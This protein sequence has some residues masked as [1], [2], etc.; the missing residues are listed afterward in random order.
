MSLSTVTVTWDQVDIGQAALAGTVT[1]ALS[2]PLGDSADGLNVNAQPPRSYRFSSGTGTSDPL[3]ANDNANL[4][5][6][7]YYQITVSIAGQQPYS[8][9]AQVNFA[10][11]ATQ[12]L[13]YL[14]ANQATTNPPAATFMPLPS[15]TPAPG[16]VPVVQTAG[17]TA[18]AWGAATSLQ[19]AQAQR[20]T[21]TS[22]LTTDVLTASTPPAF[23]SIVSAGPGDVIVRPG[24]TYQQF[25]GTGAALTDA[26]AYV[27]TN[28]MTS[29]Q[30]KALLTEL[31][32]PQQ[33]GWTM[34]RVAM[35]W[36]SFSSVPLA[37]AYTY[38]D[39]PSG[40]AD[41]SLINFSVTKDTAYI[42]P[43]IQQILAIN[44]GVRIVAAP[45]TPPAWMLATG[46]L[47]VAP[48]TF[49]D[50][51]FAAYAQ[52][53]VQFVQAYQALGIPIWAV[54]PA[55]EP[56]DPTY[57]TFTQ[58][59]ATSFVGTYLGPALAAAGLATKIL[60]L[61]D[62][63]G[64]GVTYPEG[65]LADTTAG[66][67]TA[68]VAWHGYSGGPATMSQVHGAYPAAL[69]IQTEWRSLTTESLALDMQGMAGG[70]VAGGVQNWS[71]AVL[72]WN[73]ALD[74][75]GGPQQ[76]AAGRRGAVAVNSGT[77][78]VTRNAEYYALRHLSGYVQ[79]GAVRCGSSTFGAPYVS[80]VTYPSQVTT[81]AFLNPDGSVVLYAYNGA[82]SSQTFQVIDERTGTGFPVTMV[83]G[84]LSTFVWGT[85]KQALPAVPASTPAAPSAPVLSASQGFGQTFLS[86][87]VPASAAPVTRYHLKRATTPGAE[88]TIAELPASSPFYLDLLGAAGT[89]YYTVVAVSAGGASA[90]SNEV[91]AVNAAP[92]APFAPVISAVSGGTS[93]TLSWT[94]PPPNGDVITS[95]NILRGTTSGGETSLGTA[96]Q[97]STSYTDATVTPG[98]TYY[99]KV[100]AVNVIGTSPSSNEASG[101]ATGVVIDSTSTDSN[102]ANVSSL[103]WSHT[104][105]SGAHPLLLVAV[106]YAGS[107]GGDVVSSV[108]YGGVA[109][110]KLLTADPSPGGGTDKAL[111]VW[112]LTGPAAGTASIVVTFTG[113]LSAVCGAVSLTGVSQSSPLR[114]PLPFTSTSSNAPTVSTTGGAASD[115]VMAF[116]HMR[117]ANTVTVGGSQTAVITYAQTGGTSNQLIATKQTGGTGTIVSSFS[118][119]TPDMAAEIAVAV[120]AG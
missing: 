68:G 22:D 73:M 53:F 21:T 51:N 58:S 110:T 52:Y 87:T 70:Y 79:Q 113:S 26:S 20:V 9:P 119:T 75:N 86:W 34:L 13:G 102:S 3:V 42:V 61:D 19:V 91:T 14:Q 56:L 59:E 80:Y 114:T 107:V 7:S 120:K 115:L 78:A 71:N 93:I 99:Y 46:S 106:G 72:L 82:G 96:I 24:D 44:P 30:R 16:E 41:P 98:T 103:T 101:N 62:N 40:Q 50:G 25:L 100:Q 94:A 112:Y 55:N 17:S 77:G 31:F 27:L 81:C 28:Y 10:N 95:Y 4:P 76:S 29:A 32:S 64:H 48:E 63:W 36:Q 43:I 54:T 97:G 8:F 104:V 116:L 83:A 89:W 12:T 23:T 15:G 117:G 2:E 1:F 11:G 6:G 90:A 47:G 108:T 88:V 111:D 69:Q 65:V 35:G 37:N 74:Q 45:W 109:L 84:E 118:W 5:A 33:A 66:P 85:T 67:Y 92:A 60:V 105:G 49:N 39:M 57:M 18:T 38:D